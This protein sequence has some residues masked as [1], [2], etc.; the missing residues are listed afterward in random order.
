MV[1]LESKH[2]KTT[3]SGYINCDIKKLWAAWAVLMD[4]D[5]ITLLQLIG[6]ATATADANYCGPYT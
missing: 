2:F 1:M 4:V 6:W 3:S 5:K